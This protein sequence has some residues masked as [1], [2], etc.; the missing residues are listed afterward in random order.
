MQL[1]KSTM[2]VQWTPNKFSGN[3]KGI[4][5]EAVMVRVNLGLHRHIE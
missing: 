3:P 5:A 1:S 2:M 4:R